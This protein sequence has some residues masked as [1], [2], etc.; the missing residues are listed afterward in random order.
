MDGKVSG[1]Q[2]DREL[3]FGILSVQCG[4]V[5]AEQLVQAGAAWSTGRDQTLAAHLQ[6]MGFLS[7]GDRAKIEQVVDLTVGAH[8]G[9][10]RQSLAS[11]G[12]DRAVFESFGGAMSISPDGE[13]DLVTASAR[14][15]EGP[16]TDLA[17]GIH[18]PDDE[19][20]V[21][22]EHP[23]RYSLLDKDKLYGEEQRI[24]T[25]DVA[26]AELGKGGMGR[27]LVATWRSR[28]FCPTGPLRI[29][30]TPPPVLRVLPWPGRAGWSP[31]FCGRPGLPGNWSTRP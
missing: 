30:R 3:L 11:F 8:G 9:D 5:R 21:S 31:G 12:G 28:N 7:T 23:G 10:A 24:H 29:R 17:R 13:L 1:R 14:A 20:A 27:V 22:L 2:S 16:S 6:R 26:T 4:L 18:E 25:D 15:P 19:A